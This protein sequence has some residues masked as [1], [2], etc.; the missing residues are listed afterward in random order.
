M[1]IA[2]PV[3]VKKDNKWYQGFIEDFNLTINKEIKKL[4]DI[5][6]ISE[7][8]GLITYIRTKGLDRDLANK[9]LKETNCESIYVLNKPIDLTEKQYESYIWSDYFPLCL[10]CKKNCKQS[11]IV[12]ELYCKDFEKE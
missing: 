3:V 9:L 12:K 11:H 1:K 10:K 6:N 5:K 7:Y 4:S 8:K 2:L